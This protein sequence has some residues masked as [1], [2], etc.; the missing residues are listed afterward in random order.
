MTEVKK[1]K[2]RARSRRWW[3]KHVDAWEKSGTTMLEYAKENNLEI[4]TFYSWKAKL[5]SS[6]DRK[7]RPKKIA[8]KRSGKGSDGVRFVEVSVEPQRVT[9]VELV[10]PN[11]WSIRFSSEAGDKE[12]SRFIDILEER[13]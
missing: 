12:I 8:A 13:S 7:P 11:G 9:P 4:G 3:S 10:A 1:K 6:A 5:R 2:R